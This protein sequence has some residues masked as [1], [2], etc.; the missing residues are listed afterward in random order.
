M[1]C[2]QCGIEIADKALICFR[3]GAA[4][5][6]AKFKAPARKA[7]GSWLMTAASVAALA[8]LLVV[9]VIMSRLEGAE[10]PRST[11]WM[12]VAFAVAVVVLRAIARRAGR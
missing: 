8:V 12:L 11:T 10:A 5:T 7:R 3:C 4:T 9:V 2:R 1:Q 6:D